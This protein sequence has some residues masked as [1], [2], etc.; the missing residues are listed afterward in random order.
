VEKLACERTPQAF[1]FIPFIY[2]SFTWGRCHQFKRL[3]GQMMGRKGAQIPGAYIFVR[4]RL[5]YL[6]VLSTKLTSRDNSGT[7]DFVAASR[8]FENLWTPGRDEL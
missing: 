8:F 6:W 1:L 5:R 4:R 2:Y 7:Q 3:E